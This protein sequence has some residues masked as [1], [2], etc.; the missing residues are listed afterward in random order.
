MMKKDQI[1]RPPVEIMSIKQRQKG[2]RQ[3]RVSCQYC[4]QIAYLQ[5]RSSHTSFYIRVRNFWRP[6]DAFSQNIFS[7]YTS[8][9]EK[10]RMCLLRHCITMHL[11]CLYLLLFNTYAKHKL[12]VENTYF[13]SI[14]H[15]EN[16]FRYQLDNLKILFDGKN[17]RQVY[18]QNN[19]IPKF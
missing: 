3:G 10:K 15:I 19:K 6:S 14:V 18:K 11:L 17:Q 7:E 8:G 2:R 4:V 1:I 13:V 16:A 9:K 12:R 5:K